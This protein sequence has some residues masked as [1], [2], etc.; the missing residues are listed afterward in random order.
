[1][2]V[3][4]D[5]V[6]ARARARIQSEVRDWR[7]AADART[8]LNYLWKYCEQDDRNYIRLSCRDERSI[9]AAAAREIAEINEIEL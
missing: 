5:L 2:I 1:M 9:V 6:I 4:H 7:H 8:G 3:C